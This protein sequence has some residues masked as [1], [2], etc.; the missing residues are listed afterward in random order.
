MEEE[1]P[2]LTA[3]KVL[4]ASLLID[5]DRAHEP[6]FAE[7]FAE[8]PKKRGRPPKKSGGG[9]NEGSRSSTP[10][11][12]PFPAFPTPPP[13][14]PPAS[15]PKKATKIA[16]DPVEDGSEK[17]ELERIE[18][19]R[20]IRDYKSHP[21]LAP[22]LECVEV[23]PQL[24]G[25]SLGFLRSLYG[26]VVGALAK[27]AKA[28]MV[29]QVFGF[30]CKGGEDFMVQFMKKPEYMGLADFMLQNREFFQPEL[31]IATIEWPDNW[32][33]GFKMNILLKL[34]ALGKDYPALKERMAGAN[35]QPAAP[36]ENDQK[37]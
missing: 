18:L 35:K 10:P 8:K 33:P 13:P 26:N 27:P 7:A 34:M 25:K 20:K 19:I 28:N 16:A 30:A 22:H 4:E 6:A 11:P 37:K 17:E 29:H 14:P 32:A 21:K 36:V 23:P 5:V 12:P 15:K 31:D 2:E 3:A 1:Q 9:S 24:E